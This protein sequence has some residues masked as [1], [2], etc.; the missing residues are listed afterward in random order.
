MGAYYTNNT[1][2]DSREFDPDRDV[3]KSIID[4]ALARLRRETQDQSTGG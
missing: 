4:A 3:D 2:T 1:G